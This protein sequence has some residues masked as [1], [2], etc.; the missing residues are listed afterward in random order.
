MRNV[1]MDLLLSTLLSVPTSSL[2]QDNNSDNNNNE[3]LASQGQV[4]VEQVSARQTD[5]V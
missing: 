1:L 2:Q 5:L 3:T 4:C